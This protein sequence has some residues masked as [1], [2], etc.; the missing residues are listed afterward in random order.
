MLERADEI[1]LVDLPPEELLARLREGK[2]Y[3]PEQARARR[4]TSSS[5]A[6]CSRCASSR[7]AAPPSTSTR[8][9][10]RTASEHGV[11]RDLGGGRAHP[12]VRG[13]GPG[14]ARLIRAARRMAAGLRAPWVAAYVE[15]A[16][17]R[18]C[19]RPIASASRRTCGSPS[20]SA[21]R[22]CA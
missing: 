3:L 21:A 1:E 16:T 19:P 8:T 13:P 15:H 9:C 22:W 4:S 12:G 20:R 5:A 11:E 17:W 18:P 7:C 10:R 6:T 2:V 14:S